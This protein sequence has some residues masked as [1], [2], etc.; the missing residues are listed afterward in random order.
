MGHESRTQMSPRDIMDVKLCHGYAMYACYGCAMEMPRAM[1]ML[2]ICYVN[3]F[4]RCGWALD[5]QLTCTETLRPCYGRAM[6][7]PSG[8]HM[9]AMGVLLW[10]RRGY[11]TDMLQKCGGDMTICNGC[12]IIALWMCNR[13]ANDMPSACYVCEPDLR[14][15]WYGRGRLCCG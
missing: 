9:H 3:S 13:Y 11:A 5:M 10:V 14:R 2:W 4:I 1:P 15:I 7:M 6:Y 12:A 8:C